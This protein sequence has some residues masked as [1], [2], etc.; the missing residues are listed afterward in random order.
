MRFS[1]DGDLDRFD[2]QLEDCIAGRVARDLLRLEVSGSLSLAG[3]RLYQQRLN[4]LQNQLLRL[5]I[6]GECQQAPEA[7]ELEQ[8]TARSEDPLIAQVAQQL[9][10][11]LGRVCKVRQAPAARARSRPVSRSPGSGGRASRSGWP[12]AGT[13]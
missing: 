10:Q 1:D 12:Y 13:A 7:A 3:H 9:Q 8:L 2:R 5:R 11:R 4:D 6:K